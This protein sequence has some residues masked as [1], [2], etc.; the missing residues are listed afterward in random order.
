MQIL[1][2]CGRCESTTVAPPCFQPPSNSGNR[3]R[4]ELLQLHHLHNDNYLSI[5]LLL[6][7]FSLLLIPRYI[8]GQF[9]NCSIGD[10]WGV[11]EFR[12][13]AYN[14]ESSIGFCGCIGFFYPRLFRVDRNYYRSNGRKL[15]HFF[16]RIPNYRSWDT[17]LFCCSC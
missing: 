14:V 8:L 1:W 7:A 5:M 15:S 9:S 16:P 6:L 11:S 3:I 12:N 2:C 4:K 10:N 17:K 13:N